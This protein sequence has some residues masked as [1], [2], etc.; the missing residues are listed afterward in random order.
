MRLPY[1]T[2]YTL[3]W[4]SFNSNQPK[5]P[6]RL[7]QVEMLSVKNNQPRFSDLKVEAVVQHYRWALR[8]KGQ[9]WQVV[10]RKAKAAYARVIHG[11]RNFLEIGFRIL[12]CIWSVSLTIC[13]I[14]T[15]HINIWL[16]VQTHL[17][18]SALLFS[19]F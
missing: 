8:S 15:V 6:Y 1:C 11:R 14:I 5:I 4:P 18:N 7:Q 19:A 10:E 17:H 9:L 12:Y 3:E 2:Y 13:Y 16:R